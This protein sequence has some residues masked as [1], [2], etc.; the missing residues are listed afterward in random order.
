MPPAEPSLSLFD[1]TLDDA[2]AGFRLERFELYNWGTFDRACW[3]LVPGGHNSLL[4][5]DIG[6]GKS[7]IVDGLVTLL[8][9]HNRIVYNR[10]AGAESRERTLYSYVRGEYKS[11]KDDMTG[12][13]KAVALRDENQYTVLLA[14]FTNQGY[15]RTV[16]LA[17]VFWLRDRQRNPERFFVVATRPLAIT[18][19]FSDFGDNI[20]GL[21]KKL[22]QMDEVELFSS[23]REYSTRFRRLFGI[24]SEQ[25]L[26]LFYQTVSMKSVGNLTEFVRSHMLE[27]S[28]VKER[29]AEICNNFDNLNQAHEAVVKAGAR[30]EELKPLVRDWQSHRR[31]ANRIEELEQCREALEPWFGAHKAALL[32]KSIEQ[33]GQEIEKR[34]RQIE[35]A[36]QDLRLQR[37]RESDLKTAIDESG[38]RRIGDIGREIEQLSRERTR[39]TGQEQRY[40]KIAA[41]LSLPGTVS[42]E[43]FLD[44]HR[45]CRQLLEECER[46]QALVEKEII[47]LEIEIRKCLDALSQCRKEIESLKQRQSNIPREN[48]RIRREM[49]EIL[50]KDED[51]LPFAGELLQVDEQ[52]K[53]WQG[54]IERVCRNF[55]LSLLVS[56]DLYEQV[57]HYVDRTKLKGRLVYFRV[58]EAQ[59]PVPAGE[60]GEMWR[61]LRI[62]T[63]SR[64]Y[65]WLEREIS[66]RVNY[67][68][69]DSLDEFRRRPRAVTRQGQI[70]SGGKRHEKDD[71]FALTDPSRYVLGWSNRE[72]IKALEQEAEKTEKQGASL[73]EQR[74]SLDARKRRLAS[75]RD[76]C[77][78]LLGFEHFSDINWQPLARQIQALEE[79]RRRIE[80]SS[81]L[82][83]SLRDQLALVEKEIRASEQRL[84]KLWDRRSRAAQKKE[85]REAALEEVRE[86]ILFS[87]DSEHK[88]IAAKLE[89][90]RDQV[91]PGKVFHLK[92]LDSCQRD[93]RRHI[94]AKIKSRRSKAARLSQSVLTRMNRFRNNWPAESKEVDASLEAGPEYDRM[95]ASL[96]QEDLPRHE[97]R[98]KEMLNEGTIRSIVLLRNQLDRE[99]QEIRERIATINISL[100]EARYNDGT[101]IE[102]VA[103]PAADQEIR[104]FRQ[105]LRQCLSHSLSGDEFYDES[106][107][108]LV[109]ELIDRFNGRE[110]MVDLDRRWRDKVTDVRNWFTFSA[111][112]RWQEDGS[113]KEYYSDSS[114]KSGGQKEKLAYTILASALACQ[115]GL[116]WGATRSDSFRFVVIDEAFGRGSDESTRYGLE[117]FK[118]LNLQLLIVTPLQKIHIIEDYIRA[119][120]FVHNEEG[121]SSMIRNLTI[122]EYR[123]EKERRAGAS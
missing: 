55:G 4:T 77:R 61:K 36:E 31:M 20:N 60:P 95:L 41:A 12:S 65:G 108:L 53:A 93:M 72:K 78:D 35:T 107:F 115:F 90:F 63:D 46:K 113:E 11:E 89:G 2:L 30:I 47:D 118:R 85:D 87:A 43:Q 75:T 6:S 74:T 120:Q 116:K 96:I 64:F 45:R 23:F 92:N 86:Y 97:K 81:D 28:D 69:C 34:S 100:R 123:T 1:L 3:P 10:A 84:N 102:L 91:L 40:L 14:C 8:V 32:Q 83:H 110:G 99:Q 27:P 16:T 67:I 106:R 122:E 73:V 18:E 101:Y 56:D 70:K 121:R 22:R 33:L 103:D 79:E 25:A 68:C 17:Q 98:F 37:N 38:G 88:D 109:K 71:R 105:Q 62:K 26:H 7:T 50:K 15:G 13:A 42:E 51:E 82:L 57:S 119:V 76:L 66:R 94:S 54:V 80:E 24:A 112:E 117:L 39:K 49:A 48:I 21:R 9:P 29:L 59:K 58:R 104:E 19:D 5:G 114:G 52:E 44:N 111:C